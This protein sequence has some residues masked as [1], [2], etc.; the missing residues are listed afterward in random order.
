MP[1]AMSCVV[2]GSFLYNCGGGFN[3]PTAMPCVVE[4]SF[5]YNC[6]GFRYAHGDAMCRGRQCSL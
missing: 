2:E 6:G 1:T 3:M 4:G 5:L